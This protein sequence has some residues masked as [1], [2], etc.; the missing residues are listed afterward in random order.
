MSLDLLQ[1]NISYF[2]IAINIYDMY[3]STSFFN[4]TW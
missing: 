3:L 2:V 4:Y 1:H